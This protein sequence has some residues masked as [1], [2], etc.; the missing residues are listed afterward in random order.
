VSLCYTYVL[1]G[2]PTTGGEDTSNQGCNLIGTITGT[3]DQLH[4]WDYF[5]AS[6]SASFPNLTPDDMTPAQYPLPVWTLR[7]SSPAQYGSGSRAIS[8]DYLGISFTNDSSMYNSNVSSG[9]IGGTYLRYTA[10]RFE[11]GAFQ[12]LCDA[13]SDGLESVVNG[14]IGFFVPPVI[15]TS[16]VSETLSLLNTKVPFAYTNAIFASDFTFTLPTTMSALPVFSIPINETVH[17]AHTLPITF[18]AVVPEQAR[19]LFDWFRT[20]TSLMIWGTFIAYI[21]DLAHRFFT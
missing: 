19:P 2:F 8:L 18:N 21:I 15:D 16:P 5:I 9:G 17:L 1:A 12:L 3:S 13:F 20:L 10:P 11:C 4:E 7:L 6:A 14:V